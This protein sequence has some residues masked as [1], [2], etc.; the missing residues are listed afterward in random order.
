[1]SASFVF[2]SSGRGGPMCPPIRDQKSEAGV[3]EL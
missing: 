2:C 3:P 1:M